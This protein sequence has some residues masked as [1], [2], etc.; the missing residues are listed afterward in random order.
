MKKVNILFVD[1][2]LSILQGY[3]MLFSQHKVD[4]NIFFANSGIEA[5]HLIAENSIE[6]VVTDLRMPDMD[7]KQ[8]LTILK[9][10]YPHIA[11]L[12]LS[13]YTDKE[14]AI[15]ISTLAHQILTK[16]LNSTELKNI[17]SNL[18]KQRYSLPSGNFLSI[19]SGADK[20]PSNPKEYSNLYKV[21]NSPNASVKTIADIISHDPMM[22]TKI[23]QMVNSAFFGLPY[24]I[25]D[26]IQAVSF[27]GLDIVKSLVLFVNIFLEYKGDHYAELNNFWEHSLAVAKLAEAICKEEN[28]SKEECEKALIGGL[29]H[30]TGKLVMNRMLGYFG[31]VKTEM[32]ARSLTFVEAEYL[33]WGLT[34]AEAGAFLLNLWGLPE[35]IVKILE[36]HHHPLKIELSS[37]DSLL[38][39]HLAE[40]IKNNHT[41]SLEIIDKFELSEKISK[42]SQL[43][44]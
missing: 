8:L 2:E 6:V 5:L 10:K 26:P 39:V 31:H 22:T 12:V 36:H 23:L 4:W 21:L 13:G 43:I 32:N 35:D 11:R 27:L 1:D 42:Y 15:G 20:L 17:I 14:G 16:P 41:I 7:G 28:L 24:R 38:A 37:F 40:S 9:D 34:H 44:L 18:M 3:K 29:L 30:D 25:L 33:L 19:I